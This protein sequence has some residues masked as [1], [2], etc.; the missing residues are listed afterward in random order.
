MTTLTVVEILVFQTNFAH[1]TFSINSMYRYK[2]YC[3]K[4]SLL[5]QLDCICGVSAA[6][7]QTHGSH[8]SKS[9][10]AK[11]VKQNV[12]LLVRIISGIAFALY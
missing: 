4:S 10:V 7:L 1:P 5:S 12:S 3:N 11:S 6:T 9:K 2:S 8:H